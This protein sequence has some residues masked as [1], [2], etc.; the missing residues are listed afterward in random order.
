MFEDEP[1]AN[2]RVPVKIVSAGERMWY[3]GRDFVVA[4][5]SYVQSLRIGI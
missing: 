3:D 2:Q 1:Q 5:M 4:Y